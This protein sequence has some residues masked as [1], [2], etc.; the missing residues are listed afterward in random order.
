MFLPCY[1]GKMN[2]VEEILAKYGGDINHAIAQIEPQL[3][4]HPVDT[5]LNLQ[6]L[7]NVNGNEA[8][9]YAISDELLR[10]APEDPRVLFNRGWQRLQPDRIA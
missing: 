3:K 9:A 8:A 1:T 2:F 10:L 7:H 6:V 5:R 4:E